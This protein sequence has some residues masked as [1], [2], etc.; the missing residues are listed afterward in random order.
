MHISHLVQYIQ[1]YKKTWYYHLNLSHNSLQLSVQTAEGTF[2][3]SFICK[4]R[5]DFILTFQNT[6]IIVV[7]EIYSKQP[8][9]S[10]FV[11][12]LN[13]SD[14]DIQATRPPPPLSSDNNICLS[15]AWR[16]GPQSSNSHR[17]WFAM[18]PQCVAVVKPPHCAALCRTGPGCSLIQIKRCF[19]PAL[20]QSPCASGATHY[21][22][23]GGTC[24]LFNYSA[25][26]FYPT[27]QNATWELIA[28]KIH[29]Y[30]LPQAHKL[31]NFGA[32]W[33]SRAG[34]SRSLSQQSTAEC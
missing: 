28:S 33:T 32:G 25:L 13:H 24:D 14:L 17:A 8:P 20:W 11:P 31:S 30:N 21:Y 4:E 9:S 16:T 26:H 7:T 34:T 6:W 23:R 1:R 5:M 29:L 2:W 3:H 15:S 27:I 10:L 22:M 12:T 19:L 18:Q